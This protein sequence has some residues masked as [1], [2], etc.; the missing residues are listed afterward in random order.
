M[1]T[2]EA[3]KE[4]FARTPIL[5]QTNL[6]D[7]SLVEAFVDHDASRFIQL[8]SAWYES[9]RHACKE[10][11]SHGCWIWNG[12][13]YPQT[14]GGGRLHRIVATMKFGDIGRQTVHHVCGDSRCVNPA[15]L[16]LVTRAENSAEMLARKD[17]ERF[18]EKC[19]D[20]I[21]CYN[22]S[23]P[24]LFEALPGAVRRPEG[25]EPKP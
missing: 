16:Q 18:I 22:P 2:A 6:L 11:N 5:C 1:A 7:P 23:D 19:L 3:M 8:R 14:T 25:I 12:K 17:Y 10:I 20:R 21:A 9:L 4:A 24:L 13:R 15:H